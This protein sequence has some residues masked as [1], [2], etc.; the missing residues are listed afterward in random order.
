MLFE[1]QIGPVGLLLYLMHR[2]E[3]SGSSCH[4]LESSSR[5]S[6][7]TSN[8]ARI[9]GSFTTPHEHF[10]VDSLDPSGQ[11]ILSHPCGLLTRWTT[12][13]QPRLHSASCYSHL[14]LR[15]HVSALWAVNIL[16]IFVFALAPTNGSYTKQVFQIHL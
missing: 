12:A 4:L 8:L 10:L 5:H 1:T 15:T 16:S 14:H 13:S 11:T 3:A 9:C 7:K 6:Y 2:N